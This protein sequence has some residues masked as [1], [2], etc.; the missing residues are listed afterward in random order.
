MVFFGGERQSWPPHF[1]VSISRLNWDA[2][3][4]V[5]PRLYLAPLPPPPDA[6][7]IGGGEW[8]HQERTPWL[9]GD[10]GSWG[11]GAVPLQRLGTLRGVGGGHGQH[12]LQSNWGH[13]GVGGGRKGGPDTPPRPP[14]TRDPRRGYH[15]CVPHHHH[16]TPRVSPP[17]GHPRTGGVA[18][19]CRAPPSQPPGSRADGARTRRRPSRGLGARTGPT[20]PG[21]PPCTPGSPPPCSW[22]PP[23]GAALP[24]AAPGARPPFGCGRTRSAPFGSARPPFGSGAVARGLHARARRSPALLMHM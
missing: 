16:G 22:A 17:P 21:C 5:C 9:E 15:A 3:V 7:G 11:G 4:C 18:C 23:G 24:A 1:D 8:G 14:S 2:A 12:G 6:G 19:M 13:G 20:G 10:V